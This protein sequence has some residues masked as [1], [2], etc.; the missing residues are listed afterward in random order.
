MTPITRDIDEV[1]VTLKSIE[2]NKVFSCECNEHSID[3][4]LKQ[5]LPLIHTEGRLIAT[6]ALFNVRNTS[7]RDWPINTTDWELVDADGY[8]YK[9]RT[10]SA[11]RMAS[12]HPIELID[13]TRLK[14]LIL[15]AKTK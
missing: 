12:D 7:P 1:H 11:E 8:A 15:E 5:Q 4:Q 3:C 6:E 2:R 10:L 13:G 9:A 14:E